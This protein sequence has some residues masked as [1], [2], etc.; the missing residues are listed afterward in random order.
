VALFVIFL[1]LAFVFIL[2]LWGGSLLLQGWLY[3]NPAELLPIRAA[4]SG[5]V[6]AAFLTAW[7]WIDARNPGKY[8]T[9]LEFSPVEVTEYD[10]FESVMKKANGE[11]KTMLFKKRLGT[12]GLTGDFVDDK[13]NNWLK[14]TSDSMATVILIREKDKNE[15][16][17]FKANL[18]A[19]GNFP[20]DLTQLTYTDASGRWMTADALGKVHRRKTGVLWA[21]ILLNALHFLLWWLA[22][23]LG[24]RFGIWEALGLAFVIWLFLMLL[25]Q[26]VLFKQTRPTEAALLERGIEVIHLAALSERI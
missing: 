1:L 24:M 10:S 3:Q 21:N 26:P 9:L 20:A 6:L 15:P 16:T 19:K 18:D 8:D 13:G 11:E 14:N 7:C 23:S 17:P 25:A 5:S 4:I 2:F 22:L 12:H